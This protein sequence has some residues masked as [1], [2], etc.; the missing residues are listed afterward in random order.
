MLVES[1]NGVFI[2]K[3]A[4]H[5]WIKLTSAVNVGVKTLLHLEQ[6]A[7]LQNNERESER[8]LG[9]N[10]ISIKETST[11]NSIFVENDKVDGVFGNNYVSLTWCRPQYL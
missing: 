11:L 1:K 8:N 2:E 7:D 9:I 5:E 6:L 4:Y 10:V 3:G